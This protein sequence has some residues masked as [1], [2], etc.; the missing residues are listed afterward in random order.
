MINKTLHREP[1]IEQ[2]ELHQK[3]GVKSGSPEVLAIPAK[4]S[5]NQ[6]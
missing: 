3:P 5:Y 4:I 1:K 6:L 2:H